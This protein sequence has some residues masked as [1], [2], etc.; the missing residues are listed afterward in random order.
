[1]RRNNKARNMRK[2]R[3]NVEHLS[4]EVEMTLTLKAKHRKEELYP[5]NLNQLISRQN[6]GPDAQIRLIGYICSIQIAS[7]NQLDTVTCNLGHFGPW[8]RPALQTDTFNQQFLDK[9]FRS[10]K[11]VFSK[12]LVREAERQYLNPDDGTN[13]LNIRI[14]DPC[15]VIPGATI[16]IYFKAILIR[17]KPDTILVDPTALAVDLYE[18]QDIHT[19]TQ[20]A[21]REAVPAMITTPNGHGSFHVYTRDPALG[22]WHYTSTTGPGEY[23][24]AITET[25]NMVGTFLN[26]AQSDPTSLQSEYAQ[27]QYAGKISYAPR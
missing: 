9:N 7:G 16:L 12:P 11:L 8:V 26:L 14:R 4:S 15:G 17:P 18:D 19:G 5:V 27:E 25:P 23:T 22:S 6:V 20:P 10:R 24:I 1:M 21:A 2:K 3:S 13:Y